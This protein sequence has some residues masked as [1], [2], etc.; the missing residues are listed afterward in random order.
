METDIDITGNQ[1]QN[2]PKRQDGL[3]LTTS[4]V[5]SEYNLRREL[6]E[7]VSCTFHTINSSVN[8]E[9]EVIDCSVSNKFLHFRSRQ[10]EILKH[11]HTLFLKIRWKNNLFYLWRKALEQQIWNQS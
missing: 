8:D 7:D 9:K 1:K 3:S 4:S 11:L 10:Y 5:W 2:L 6:E